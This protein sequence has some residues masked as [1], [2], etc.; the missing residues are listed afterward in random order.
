[1]FA[2]IASVAGAVCLAVAASSAAVAGDGVRL[3]II[4][5]LAGINQFT[6]H[7]EPFWTKEIV[8]RTRGRLRPTIHAFDRSGLRGQ[9]ML[10]LM[11]LGVVPFGTAL[12]AVAAGDEPELNAVDLPGLNIDIAALRA[13]VKA[14]RPHLVRLLRERYEVELL[15]I[16]TYPAQVIYCAKAFRGLSDL[17]GRKVRTSSVGQSELVA[18]LGATPVI[19]PFAETVSAV[20]TGVVD[21]AITGTLSGFEVGLSEVTT[22]VHS[23]AIS[24]GLSVFGANRTAFEALAPELQDEVRRGVKDLE[25]R[26]WAAAEEETSRGL[27]CNVGSKSCNPA[28]AGRMT[29][30][31]VNRADDEKRRELLVRVVLPSWIERCGLSCSAAWN[32]TLGPA[33][34]I[35]APTP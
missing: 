29:L 34:G 30:V 15:G 28:R 33:L 9:D 8:E 20:R 24:W 19:T 22:H 7:E 14:Y 35:A 13:S 27:A 23:M 18:A 3:R 25:E 4:G 6:Q 32:T 2:A 21:C 26:I 10:Q 12:L 17:A 16:Y 31:P 11:K 1:M 5:G